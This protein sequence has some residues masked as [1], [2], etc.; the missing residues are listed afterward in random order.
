MAARHDDAH[1]IDL[2]APACGPQQ[3]YASSGA[4]DVAAVQD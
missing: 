2:Q 1:P 4:H 3:R